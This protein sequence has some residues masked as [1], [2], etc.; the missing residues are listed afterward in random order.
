VHELLLSLCLWL[1]VH[2]DDGSVAAPPGAPMP[3]LFSDFTG[4]DT[5]AGECF[6][7]LNLVKFWSDLSKF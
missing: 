2:E 1:Q 5:S 7:Y 6:Q 4:A 3:L